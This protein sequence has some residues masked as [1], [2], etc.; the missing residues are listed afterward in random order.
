MFIEENI[1]SKIKV[2]C[3]LLFQ[4]THVGNDKN[5]SSFIFCYY[6]EICGSL[7]I[8]NMILKKTALYTITGIINV[9]LEFYIRYLNL[10]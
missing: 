4:Y 7:L 8:C 2:L 6:Y 5:T 1:F 10:I 3:I 9:R